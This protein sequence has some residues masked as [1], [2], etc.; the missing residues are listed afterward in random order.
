M[1]EDI[2]M[3]VQI[4]DEVK[5]T[6]TGYQGIAMAIYNWVDNND[7]VGIQKEG[8]NKDGV[9][10][11]IRW[12]DITRLQVIESSKKLAIP[13]PAP[14][15]KFYDEVKDKP[16]GFLGKVTGMSHWITGCI[17]M[18]VTSNQIRQDGENFVEMSLPQDRLELVEEAKK[19]E[20][21]V[22]TGG[23]KNHPSCY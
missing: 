17:R 4:G 10:E 6:I 9:P 3:L 22:K 20:K 19:E 14:K 18:T 11:D 8:L 12:F 5:D 16:T 21:P 1:E 7:T 15:F 2:I 23:P 13:C